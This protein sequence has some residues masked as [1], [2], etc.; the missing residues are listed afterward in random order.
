MEYRGFQLRRVDGKW[1]ASTGAGLIT[2]GPFAS[3]ARAEAAVDAELDG[4]GQHG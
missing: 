1:Y 3:R 2:L 4:T